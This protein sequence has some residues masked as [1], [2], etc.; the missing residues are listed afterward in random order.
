[1]LAEA[2]DFAHGA[3]AALLGLEDGGSDG[4]APGIEGGDE[5]VVGA[6]FENF[7]QGRGHALVLGHRADEG[8]GGHH[9]A[10]LD[11]T[12]LEIAGDRVAQSTQNLGR[13][14]AFLLRV[15]HVALGEDRAASRDARRAAGRAHQAA[16]LLDRVA[17]AERL[18]I[19]ERAGAGGALAAAVVIHD[20]GQCGIGLL[21][22]ADVLGAFA[23]DFED[24][25][26]LRVEQADHP[27]DGFELVLEVDAEDLRDGAAAG[28]GDA[29]ALDADLGDHLV[30]LLEEV[31]GGLDGAAD[32]A[33]IGGEQQ[34]E[35][36]ASGGVPIHEAEGGLGGA[37][38]LKHGA[39]LG[40][41][42]RGQLEAD[43]ADIE[44]DIDTHRKGRK[45]LSYTMIPGNPRR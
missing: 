29:H 36:A 23:A 6:E 19:E 3:L 45:C 28:A 25:A 34:G 16:D 7:A 5:E 24:G 22:E 44:T 20:A 30:E 42:Q 15:D 31:E 43:G 10:A 32:D 33:A 35:A 9:G 13:R 27:G 38:G 1:M 4:S 18:L 41:A 12:G 26:G 21:L 37:E 40:L 14:V 39:I 11:D 2:V 17:H 8:D